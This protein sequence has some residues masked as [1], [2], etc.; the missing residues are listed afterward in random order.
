MTPSAG[1]AAPQRTIRHRIV[2]A[3]RESDRKA[4]KYDRTKRL[5]DLIDAHGGRDW[6]HR[7]MALT[8]R[9]DT[10]SWGPPR[11]RDLYIRDEW[12]YT[13]DHSKGEH[14][15]HITR[16]AMTAWDGVKRGESWRTFDWQ[17]DGM[18]LRVGWLG[19]D[20]RLHDSGIDGRAE[21]RLFRRWFLWD[22]WA[23]AEW[24]GLRRWLYY[25]GLSHAVDHRVPFT[26]G[27]TPPSGSGGYSH[28]HCDV[29]RPLLAILS[30]RRTQHDG[31]HRFNNYRW[32]EAEERVQYDPQPIGRES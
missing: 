10:G 16:H 13:D 15:R 6:G 5:R 29:R 2:R 4:G 22:S 7:L 21:L 11:G 28:W 31:P 3:L 23:K 27:L 8:G 19:D 24:F 18:T 20:G 26:C 14:Q 30:G 32:D 12:V 17:D 1:I 25:K 9:N